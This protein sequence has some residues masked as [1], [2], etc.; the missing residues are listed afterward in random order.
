MEYRHL[1][2]PLK[3]MLGYLVGILILTVLFSVHIGHLSTINK[4]YGRIA[5]DGWRQLNALQTLYSFGLQL[6]LDLD[7]N[8]SRAKA[9]LGSIDY[10]FFN[11]LKLSR[12]GGTKDF[13]VLVREYYAFRASVIRLIEVREGESPNSGIG[14]TEREFARRFNV[15][16][17]RIF[18][19]IERSRNNVQVS[20]TL[21]LRRV[22]ELLFLNT[23]L[24]P[25]SFLF[26]YVYGYFLSNHTALRLKNFMES[27][28]R[29]LSGDYRTKIED[30]S[31][32]EIGQIAQG[33]NELARRL[34]SK[35]GS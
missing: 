33:I 18:V 23:I 22:N 10:W 26:L 3:M 1:G 5:Q 20:E 21:F 34:E 6:K 25:L 7:E 19:D 17:G 13:S 32:D 8:P 15:F 11:Y 9:G 29:I 4:D 30:N 2:F 14:A 28:R 31:K 27:L 12:G 16:M 35:K 24:A